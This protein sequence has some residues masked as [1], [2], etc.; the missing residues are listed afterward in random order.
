[1]TILLCAPK[2]MIKLFRFTEF[3]HQT[4]A[5][6]SHLRT[7]DRSSTFVISSKESENTFAWNI[8]S[9]TDV[10][11][12]CW[13]RLSPSNGLLNWKLNIG[14]LV[15]ISYWRTVW[16]SVFIFSTGPLLIFT[17]E[18]WWDR[19]KT[20]WWAILTN[21]ESQNLQRQLLLSKAFVFDRVSQIYSYS[22]DNIE[23][24]QQN[25][26]EERSYLPGRLR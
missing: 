13:C 11:S 23:H 19:G 15:K 16:Y 20:R 10:C 9:V 12:W 25:G 3:Y 2:W 7:D 6:L 14:Y 8:G 26:H 22:L 18:C 21:V 4:P 5:R 17:F 1:M 24:D